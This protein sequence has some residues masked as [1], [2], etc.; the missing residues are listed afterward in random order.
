MLEAIA[1]IVQAVAGVVTGAM[2][3]A[4]ARVTQVRAA[5][6]ARVDSEK[7]KTQT[8]FDIVKTQEITN[9]VVAVIGFVFLIVFIYMLTKKSK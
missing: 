9:A 5:N 3:S 6:Q 2:A 7:Q 8:L 1:L 4:T